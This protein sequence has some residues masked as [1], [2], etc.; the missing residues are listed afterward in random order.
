[1]VIFLITLIAQVSWKTCKET[2]LLT[3]WAVTNPL[4]KVQFETFI[5][6]MLMKEEKY[7]WRC[8]Q[9]LPYEEITQLQ[10]TTRLIVMVCVYV[11]YPE[12]DT[13]LGMMCGLC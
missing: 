2:N 13:F 12:P 6:K 9:T 11:K 4:F 1:M 10:S 3:A 8:E 5:F 7:F